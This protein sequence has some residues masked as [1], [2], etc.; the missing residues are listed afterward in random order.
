MYRKEVL[1][2]GLRIVMQRM[3][4]VRSLSLGCWVE[5]GVV[6][7][8]YADNGISHFLEHML[9][10]GTPR[11]NARQIAEAVEGVGGQ[12]DAYTDKDYTFV[13]IRVLDEY[14][15]LSVDLITDMIINSSLDADEL[16][17]EK[18][19]L[20]EEVRMYEDM[21]ESLIHDYLAREV[22]DGHSL[23]MPVLGRTD[24]LSAL[25]REDLAGYHAGLYRPDRIIISAAGSFDEEALIAS[26]RK[27]AG[28][29]SGKAPQR[30]IAVP[31]RRKGINLDDRV[32]E[33]AH[34]ALGYRAVPIGSPERF[35]LTLLDR[36]LGGSMSSRLFQ[37]IREK[38]G[39]AYAVYSYQ[40]LYGQTGLF[41]VY[42]GTAAANACDVLRLILTEL[43]RI[44][45]DGVSRSE[46][47]GAVAQAKGALYLAAESS[48]SVMR[49]MGKA[50]MYLHRCVTQQET[51]EALE[52][53][54]PDQIR[55]TAAGLLDPAGM[56]LVTIGITD[57]DMAAGIR[58]IWEEYTGN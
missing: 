27:A 34:L 19:V 53:V 58:S 21:P 41:G 22:M 47:A 52:A 9:F 48:S 35:P 56:S 17:R 43:D 29:L 4:H 49:R 16:E 38:R 14:Q 10:K 40:S 11:R 51:V 33:Q 5:A 18:G 46:L 12:I 50:E 3:P 54:T 1:G 45:A 28:G 13:Y 26:I 37:E 6:D 31:P 23:A 36:I 25:T 39:L 57:L 42:A 2:N 44:R 8:S 30:S 32:T 15:D 20:S 24:V 55:D 7:E